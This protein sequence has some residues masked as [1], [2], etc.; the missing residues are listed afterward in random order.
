MMVLIPVVVK[1]GKIR[2]GLTDHVEHC[3]VHR[4]ILYI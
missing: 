2:L 1:G 3:E 4:S